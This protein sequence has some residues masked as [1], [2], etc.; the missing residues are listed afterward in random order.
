MVECIE[1][2]GMEAAG[3]GD[4]EESVT[5]GTAGMSAE[6]ADSQ[7]RATADTMGAV[8][9]VMVMMAVKVSTWLRQDRP[10][11]N[12]RQQLCLADHGWTS[13]HRRGHMAMRQA[14]FHLETE[15]VEAEEMAALEWE[16]QVPHLEQE[17]LSIEFR[18]P[19]KSRIQGLTW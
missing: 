18:V 14:L 12:L 6:G 19:T 16:V 13:Q 3:I 2:T 7:A 9:V 5:A 15:V 4:K 17:D 8:M 1:T 10:Q 11:G